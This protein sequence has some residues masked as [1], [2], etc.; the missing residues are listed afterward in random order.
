MIKGFR[1]EIVKFQSGKFDRIWR[2]SFS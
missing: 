2:F 1:N